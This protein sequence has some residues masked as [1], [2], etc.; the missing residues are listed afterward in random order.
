[1][2]ASEFKLRPIPNSNDSYMGIANVKEQSQWDGVCFVYCRRVEMEWNEVRYVD[3]LLASSLMVTTDAFDKW[4]V[5]KRERT[6]NKARSFHL[7][8]SR[9]R[10]LIV[11][12]IIN[13]TMNRFWP[14]WRSAIQAL[15]WPLQYIISQSEEKRSID[16]R[17]GDF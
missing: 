2:S 14:F 13:I 12:I 17:I 4:R 1:M 16:D 7:T 9:T 8:V 6:H 3:S 5:L 15:C 10:L 11:F